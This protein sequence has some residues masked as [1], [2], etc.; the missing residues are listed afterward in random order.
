[1]GT[2]PEAD[3]VDT[4]QEVVTQAALVTTLVVTQAALVTTQAAQVTTL[5]VTPAVVLGAITWAVVD[6]LIDTTD[7]CHRYLRFLGS[8][9]PF[10]ALHYSIICFLKKPFFNNF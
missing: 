1:M 6:I 2:H 10:D 8:A 5:V 9:H 3:T 4:A 7:I